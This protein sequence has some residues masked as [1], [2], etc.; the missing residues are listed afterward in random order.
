MPEKKVAFDEFVKNVRPD[1]KSTEPIVY[2]SGFLGE[3][4][5]EGHIR[6]YADVSLNQFVDI[7]KNAVA[8]SVP[9]TKE[10]SS[11]GG[12]HLWVKQNEVASNPMPGS[13]FL[14]GDIYNQYRR[15]LYQPAPAAAKELL[16]H[17]TVNGAGITNFVPTHPG[18]DCGKSIFFRCAA[19]FDERFAQYGTV[20]GNERIPGNLGPTNRPA[21]CGISIGKFLCHLP[22]FYTQDCPYVTPFANT[23][24]TQPYRAA[25]FTPYYR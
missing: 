3:S 22:P 19:P 20:A 16:P 7:P 6:V 8:H 23:T 14:H 21:E 11:F 24:E 2:L 12:S 17:C 25:A 10:E 1:A 18:L 15:D 5:V 9:M 4:P 13:P